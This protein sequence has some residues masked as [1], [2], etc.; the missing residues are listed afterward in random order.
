WIALL[1]GGAFHVVLIP[2]AIS[3]VYSFSAAM[4][5]AYCAFLPPRWTAAVSR[6]CHRSFRPDRAGTLIAVAA[7]LAAIAL[8]AS[9]HPRWVVR[10]GRWSLFVAALAFCV[11]VFRAALRFR[12]DRGPSALPEG[13]TSA[14]VLGL[15]IANGAMPYLAVKTQGSFAM[16]SNLR[17]EING[18]H[19]FLPTWSLGYGSGPFVHLE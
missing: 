1:L 14:V 17:T 2:L 4:L 6:A 9:G 5:A 3:G 13:A 15:V 8:V 12:S 19:L 16:F 11:A 10:A 7:V 18:N